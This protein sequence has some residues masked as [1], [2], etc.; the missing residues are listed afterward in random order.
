METDRQLKLFPRVNILLFIIQMF[1]FSV[2]FINIITRHPSDTLAISSWIVCCT[3][4]I[5]Y[6]ILIIRMRIN[7]NNRYGYI[8]NEK[9][10]LDKK[11]FYKKFYIWDEINAYSIS[12][13][14]RI[15][16]LKFETEKP[17]GKKR[18]IRIAPSV[19]GMYINELIQKINEVRGYEYIKR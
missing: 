4:A 8:I 19:Y 11:L 3:V 10:I 2:L 17:N 13:N 1:V 5:F 7:K 18:V 14:K 15:H 6:V 9:G 12:D 16:E